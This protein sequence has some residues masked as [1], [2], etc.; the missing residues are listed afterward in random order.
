MR[1]YPSCVGQTSY[2]HNTLSFT[3]TLRINLPRGFTDL[4]FKMSA[5]NFDQCT[6][7]NNNNS[8]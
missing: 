2:H 1:P 3:K 7:H 6:W 8:G 4:G 5:S